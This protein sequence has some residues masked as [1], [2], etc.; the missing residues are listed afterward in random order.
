LKD[1]KNKMKD[2]VAL[3]KRKRQNKKFPIE[4]EHVLL[5]GPPGTGKTL[6]A[7]A[8]ARDSGAF[9]AYATGGQFAGKDRG[10]KE[11]KIRMFL[12]GVIKETGGEPCILFIDEFEKMTEG[13]K[14]RGKCT[15]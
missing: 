14:V 5:Y 6:L 1:A 4:P 10:E 8:A 2:N 9:F 11:E 7:Q 13:E 12:N 15:E 3:I